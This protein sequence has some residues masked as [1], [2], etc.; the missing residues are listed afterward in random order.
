[1]S[2]TKVAALRT[3]WQAEWLA[4]RPAGHPH[5]LSFY[6]TL[7]RSREGEYEKGRPFYLPANQMAAQGLLE[8]HRDRKLYLRLTSELVRIG[9][10][11]RVKEAAFTHDGRRKPAQFMFTSRPTQRSDNLVFLAAR[12]RAA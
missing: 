7:R 1:M 6:L 3:I 8:G 10:I 12:R 2:V 4:F 5:A 9:L 11:E